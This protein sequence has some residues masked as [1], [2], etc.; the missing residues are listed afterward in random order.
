M[1]VRVSD[2]EFEQAVS[3]IICQVQAERVVG[4]RG[5]AWSAMVAGFRKSGCCDGR[6]VAVIERAIS[7]H[8]S[9]LRA[10]AIRDL[11]SGCE[12]G[13]GDSNAALVPVSE[14]RR[15]L[16]R[17]APSAGRSSPTCPG[18]AQPALRDGASARILNC[19][20]HVGRCR[21]SCDHP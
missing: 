8:L 9:S 5:S 14:L 16:C 18:P 13:F 11:W 12:S 19:D 3:D 17:S 20:R 1:E 6:I 15:F 7:A 4:M 21:L 10:P 2:C